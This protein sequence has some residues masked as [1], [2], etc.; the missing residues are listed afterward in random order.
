MCKV[1]Q[2]ELVTLPYQTLQEASDRNKWSDGPAW[3]WGSLSG[4]SAML[5]ETNGEL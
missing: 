2:E 5:A 3:E 4:A 1:S